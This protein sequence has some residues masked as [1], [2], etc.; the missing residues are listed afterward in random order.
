[1]PILK[2]CLEVIAKNFNLFI[3][4]MPHREH[5]FSDNINEAFRFITKI[6][7]DDTVCELAVCVGIEQLGYLTFVYDGVDF[8]Q[9][10]DDMH[11]KSADYKILSLVDIPCLKSVFTECCNQTLIHPSSSNH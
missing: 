7:K 10:D 5:F 4:I 3:Y 8:L 1:M 11:D 9:V 2:L 6:V